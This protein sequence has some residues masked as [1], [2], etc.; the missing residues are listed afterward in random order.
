MKVSPVPCYGGL[1]LSPDGRRLAVQVRASGSDER[2]LGC[3]ERA[4]SAHGRPSEAF[5]PRLPHKFATW[6]SS[7]PMTETTERTQVAIADSYVP[8]RDWD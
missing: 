5:T 1:V 6:G 3:H 8:E 2:H 7:R 4:S